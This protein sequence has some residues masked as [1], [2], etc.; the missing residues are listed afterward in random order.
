MLAER[1]DRIGNGSWKTGVSDVL[2][3]AGWPMAAFPSEWCPLLKWPVG[4]L[5]IVYSCYGLASAVCSIRNPYDHKKLL[6]EIRHMDRTEKRSSIV[7]VRD[8]SGDARNRYLLYEDVRWDCDFFPN[9]DTEGSVN[10]EKPELAKWLSGTFEIPESSFVLT[11]VREMSHSKPSRSHG[12][13]IRDYVY[14]LWVADVTDLPEAWKRE[15]FKVGGFSC[16]WET[17]AGMESNPHIMKINEDV[18]G[19]VKGYVH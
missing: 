1:S 12:G 13:E 17:I 18:V 2:A 4:I 14:R 7:A 19:M 16:R 8:A 3:G 15:R 6:E 5:G 11:Y 10:M 9:H